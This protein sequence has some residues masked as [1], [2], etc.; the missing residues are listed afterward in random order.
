MTN[1]MMPL[2]LVPPALEP[3]TL[4][5]AKTFLRVEGAQDDD[6]VMALLSAARLM[7]EA[8]SG[9]M[10][11][12][13][14]W[15]IVLDGWPASGRVRLPVSPLRSIIAVRVFGADGQAQVLA[16]GTLLAETGAEPPVLVQ[17]QPLPPPGR[18]NQGIEIDV[19]IGHGPLAADVPAPLRQA[20]LRLAA[21][22]FENRGDALA[23]DATALPSEIMALINPYRRKRL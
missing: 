13:Q 23:G 18:S 20:V 19:L 8:A 15:R 1:L 10:L 9:R 21:F 2:L 11:I 14:T 7:V 22:W 5:D 17:A 16:T 4:A 12:D 3:V 6:L